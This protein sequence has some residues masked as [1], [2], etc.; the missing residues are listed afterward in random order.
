MIKTT[1]RELEKFEDRS[2]EA[3]SEGGLEKFEDRSEEEDREEFKDF[4]YEKQV[5][6][7]FDMRDHV[8]SQV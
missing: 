1:V 3:D 7:F 2:E 5:L 4:G 8:C 6:S